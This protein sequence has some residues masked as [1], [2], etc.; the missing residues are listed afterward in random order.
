MRSDAADR[1]GRLLEGVDGIE[2]PHADDADHKRSW[3]VYVVK[4]AEGIDRDAVLER[5][6]A[7]G[8]EAGHL[9]TG[10]P[11]PAVHARALWLHRR[12]VP[13]SRGRL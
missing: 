10:G 13:R 6:G 7:Q 8:I 4:V 11:P 9:R 5:L 12:R 3:F 2:P 1:Y